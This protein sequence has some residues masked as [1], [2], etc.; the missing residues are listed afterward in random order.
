[1]E[2]F[3]IIEKSPTK[4]IKDLFEEKYKPEQLSE[5]IGNKE[6]ILKIKK[7][8]FTKPLFIHGP[9]GIGKSLLANLFLQKTHNIIE[10]DN[11]Q[12]KNKFL[13]KL[14]KVITTQSIQRPSA[15][16]IENIDKNIGEGVYY[17]KF[18][19]ILQKY[20]KKTP[21][22][23]ICSG[24]T[25]KKKYN[26]P[27]KTEIIELDYPELSEMIDFCQYIQS[28][29]KLNIVPAAIEIIIAASHYDFRKILHY[30]K[31]I[32]L[33]KVK[34]KY[35][36]KDI[37]S[38]VEFSDTDTVYSAYELIEEAFNDTN[39]KTME[40]LIRNCYPDQPLV[41]DILYSNCTNSLK[42]EDSLSILEGISIADTY[43]SYIYKNQAWELR[44]Y[45]IVTGSINAFNIIK[46]RKS[47]R[48]V[49][50]KKNQI[51]NLPWITSKNKSALNEVCFGV[52]MSPLDVLYTF[53]NIIIPLFN[54]DIEDKTLTE[55][56]YGILQKYGIETPSVYSKLWSL[57]HKKPMTRKN[58]TFLEKVFKQFST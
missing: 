3:L 39:E 35:T 32:T 34:N 2:N 18:L 38:I 17:T 46:Q 31:L 37:I 50:L 53:K 55:E 28:K 42:L 14:Q 11:I 10:V 30:F 56:K 54:Q 52:F 5:F 41:N 29:E 20:N 44:D 24:E 48:Y 7:W 26:T 8:D 15:F 12:E 13:E 6:A 49:K 9:H 33:G 58:K 43:Q 19:E 45:N 22:V 51:N 21:V 4:V 1:M 16:I 36:K 27:S 47:K 40:E 25:L 23:C 57:L